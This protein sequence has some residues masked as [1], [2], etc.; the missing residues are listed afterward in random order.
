MEEILK[1]VKFI[2]NSKKYTEEESSSCKQII[3][4]YLKSLEVSKS[5]GFKNLFL[6]VNKED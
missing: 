1:L 3:N 5:P 2:N 4:D 6:L